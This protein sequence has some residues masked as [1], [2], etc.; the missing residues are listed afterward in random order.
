M[1]TQGPP[2]DAIDRECMTRAIAAAATVRCA[3]S[4]NPWVGA[5]LR[6]SDGA[7]FEG[8]TAPPGGPHAEV[9]AIDAAGGE[10]AG[11]TLYVTLEPCNHVGRTGP[12]TEAISAAGITRVVVGIVDPDHRV[13]GDGISALEEAGV[14]VVVG[15]QSEQVTAQ[16]TPYITHRQTGRPWV[17]LKLAATLDGGTAAPNGTSKWITSTEARA[18]GHRL[19]AESDAIVVGAGTVRRDDPSLTVRDYHPEVAKGTNLDPR[20]VVLGSIPEDAKVHPCS[21]FHGDLVDLLNQLGSEGVMQL[22][23]EGGA[24]VAGEFH[25]A[26][27]VDRYVIYL[28]PALF[29]GDDAR[30][31][32]AGQGAFDISEIWRGQFS[33]LERI[34][35][36][37]RVELTPH[38]DG[39]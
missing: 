3:T 18:D 8:A 2:R 17:V 1:S 11:S 37:L 33:S 14:D 7:M 31:V 22:L 9:A 39:E 19:R 28:A 29:G 25:R 30:G 16:L 27:L 4:P 34:G 15:V 13:S 35:T 23:V 21:E 38:K 12:C 24:G 26:G 20:R 36:D 5:V 32:F 10:A 6:T